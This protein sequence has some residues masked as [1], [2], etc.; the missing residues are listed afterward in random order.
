MFIIT[1]L[2][3]LVSV[4]QNQTIVL[5][6]PATVSMTVKGNAGPITYSWA[7]SPANTTHWKAVDLSVNAGRDTE[8]QLGNSHFLNASV[9]KTWQVTFDKQ[10]TYTLTVTATDGVTTQ[11]ATTVVQVKRK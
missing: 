5:G 2:T 7:L 3:M 4:S 1:L 11:R 6:K 9:T 8:T 10:G